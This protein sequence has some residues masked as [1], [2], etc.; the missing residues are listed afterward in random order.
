MLIGLSGVILAALHAQETVPVSPPPAEVQPPV[1]PAPAAPPAPAPPPAPGQAPAGAVW[2][3]P[4]Q[5][6]PPTRGLASS[7]SSRA[8]LEERTGLDLGGVWERYALEARPQETFKEFALRRFR[9]RQG[10]GIGLTLGGAA[11]AGLGLGLLLSS[12]T[13]TDASPGA[14]LAD[15]LGGFFMVS[16]GTSMMIPGPILWAINARRLHRLRTAALPGA[17]FGLALAPGGLRLWF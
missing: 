5:P 3:Y 4:A 8:A 9:R 16:I 14:R 17:R 13:R 15:G 2:G 6:Q 11:L 1:A 10:V 12:E 7:P